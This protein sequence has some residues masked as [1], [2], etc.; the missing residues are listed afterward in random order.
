MTKKTE[1]LKAG[2]FARVIQSGGKLG[3]T[4]YRVDSV[5]GFMCEVCEVA[6]DGTLYAAQTSD[7]SLF[8][9]VRE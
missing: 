7:I 5:D 6:E 9:K 3:P 8:R 4:L 1:H 2:D